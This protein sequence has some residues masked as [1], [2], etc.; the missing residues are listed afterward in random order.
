[1]RKSLL[2]LIPIFLFSAFV[3]ALYFGWPNLQTYFDLKKEIP[4]KESELEKRK[5]H[6]KKLNQME[7]KLEK[8]RSSLEKIQKAFPERVSYPSVLTY[9]QDTVKKSGLILK[10]LSLSKSSGFYREDREGGSSKGKTL[11]EKNKN[12]RPEI[13]GLQPTKF[14]LSVEG[15]ISSLDSFIQELYKSARLFSVENISIEGKEAGKEGRTPKE[16]MAPEEETQEGE[17]EREEKK[18]EEESE[19]TKGKLFKFSLTIKIYSQ[20]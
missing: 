2:F 5:E 11:K 3:V 7:A 1:M 20:G 15:T 4:K 18:E 8:H 16:K 19:K 10:S 13:S 12:G 17:E 6:I 9:L 14:T